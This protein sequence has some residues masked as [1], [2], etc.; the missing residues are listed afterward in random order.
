MSNVRKDSVSI[1]DSKLAS[2]NS[3]KKQYMLDSSIMDAQVIAAINMSCDEL[4]LQF[5]EYKPL[6]LSSQ[7]VWTRML[8]VEGLF[9]VF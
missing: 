7:H 8:K 2:V 9:T 4:A 1:Y 3:W 5:K 6:G